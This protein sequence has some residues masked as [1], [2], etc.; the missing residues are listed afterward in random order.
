MKEQRQK[1]RK[2]TNEPGYT[3]GS[4]SLGEEV[5]KK[6]NQRGQRRSGK[7]AAFAPVSGEHWE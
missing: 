2:K 3:P 1:E 4:S 7:V 6:A 5:R